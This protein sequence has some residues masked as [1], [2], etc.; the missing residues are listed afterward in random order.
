MEESERE[1]E[2]MLRPRDAHG[3]LRDRSGA[4]RIYLYLLR[5]QI[6]AE[7]G[8]TWST[9]DTP[10]HKNRRDPKPH[11]KTEAGCRENSSGRLVR[12]SQRKGK[13]VGAWETLRQGQS[14]KLNRIDAVAG[15][16][17][18]RCWST[19]PACTQCF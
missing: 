5:E 7:G 18:G 1:R 11:P 13:S 14:K 16:E 17:K 8:L 15:S 6:E 9:L 12:A 10:P 4:Q 3:G 19:T 2:G